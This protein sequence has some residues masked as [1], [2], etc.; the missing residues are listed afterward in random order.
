[1]KVR[2]NLPFV[3]TALLLMLSGIL[4]INPSSFP[5]YSIRIVGIILAIEAFTNMKK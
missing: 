1:M 3:F 4:I 5:D 2:K